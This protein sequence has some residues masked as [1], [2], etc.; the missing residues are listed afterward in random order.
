MYREAASGPAVAERL[1]HLGHGS[2]KDLAERLRRLQPKLVVTC[3]RGSSD[4]A[5]TF[6]KYL[7]ETMLGLPVAS[8]A[9]SITSVYGQ[10]LL[11]K[12]ALFLA[13]SQSG[14]SPDLVQSALQARAGGAFTL[15][16][17]N[18][19]GSPLEEAC[20]I[21]LPLHAGPESSVA[22]TKSFLASLIALE[23]LVAAWSGDSALG[24][25]LTTLPRVMAEAWTMN[26]AP[27]VLPVLVDARQLFVIGRGLG[28]GIAQEIAL[29]M[30]ETC[31]L[32]GEAYS[33][34]E[35]RHGPMA[36][37]SNGFPVLLLATDGP[38]QQDI[39]DLATV[40]AQRGARVMIAGAA[41]LAL[42]G[43]V[44]RLSLPQVEHPA[45]L[46]I[47]AAQAAYRM[48]AGLAVARGLNPDNPPFLKKVTETV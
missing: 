29:K 41:D 13:I 36:L 40:F 33:A 28:L 6:A 21:T 9:P 5:A 30:K 19:P 8:H 38:T 27:A 3:A 17:I 24:Q 4:H 14:G 44:I 47:A 45:M 35:V 10:T 23:H 20:E 43:S 25:A 46:P 48:I 7:I 11:V 37:V 2:Y 12:N 34:A 1:A 18:A 39:V 42:P 26:W 16:L 32:H 22:A 15:S 31:Q